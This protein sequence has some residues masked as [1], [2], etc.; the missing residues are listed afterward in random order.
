MEEQ[1]AIARTAYS[2]KGKV[3]R[4]VVG[5]GL[6][7]VRCAVLVGV[8]LVATSLSAR[9]LDVRVVADTLTLHAEQAPLQDVLGRLQEAGIRIRIDPRVNPSVSA[10]YT[11]RDLRAA[12]EDLLS[13]CDY[14]LFFT[15]L[16]GPAGALRRI[17]EI[18]IY[19]RGDRRALKPLPGV[20]DNLAR[21]QAPVR[22]N[23]VT[24]VKNEILI[25]LRRDVTPEAFRALLAK[26]NGTVIDSIPAL[27][28]YRIRLVPGS[29]IPAALA[30][31]AGVPGVER[32]EPNLVY[33]PVAPQQV[34]SD[35]AVSAGSGNAGVRGTA[36]VAVLDTGLLPD[37][38]LGTRVLASLDAVAP[39][40]PLADAVGHGTQMAMIA[41]GMA[42]PR[43]G[44]DA[45]TAVPI[46]P[47]RAFDDNGYASGFALMRSLTFALDNGARVISMS[48]GSETD[49]GF[50]SDAMNYAAARGAVLVAAAGN[51]P[52]GQ[53][54]YP[55]ANANVIAV[56][57]LE[58]DGTLWS[59]S[60]YG[61]FVKLAA[62]SFVS[63][64]VGYQGPPGLYAGTSVATAFTANTVARYFSLHPDATAQ[65]ATAALTAALSRGTGAATSAHPEIASLD[66]RAVATLL[67]P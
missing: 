15:R 21:A 18:N 38:G 6:R 57:A 20:D 55:A 36:A 43:G 16:D 52:T 61:S 63:L 8:A 25:R 40:R 56:A 29:S 66:A 41:S 62:P 2:G 51:E 54:I 34:G 1:A 50:L 22:S 64:P 7:H 28:I 30:A 39:E 26:I 58:P 47:I 59:R 32:A 14:A 67:K 4:N 10:N 65:E 24:C 53:P 12:I 17:S 27:G 44:D 3:L 42:V 9:P 19:M 23:V 46:I 45:S 60:N 35:K 49:S 37:A 48:W 13:D 31:L 5:Y 11:K 33:R